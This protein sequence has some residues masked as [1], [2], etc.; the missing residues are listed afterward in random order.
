MKAAFTRKFGGPEILQVGDLPDLTAGLGQIGVNAMA[1]SINVAD[2]KVR[3]GE[4]KQANFPLILKK[5]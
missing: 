1:A 4:Y 2:W 5:T 3:A